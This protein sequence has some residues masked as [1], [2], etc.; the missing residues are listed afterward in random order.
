MPLQLNRLQLERE[1]AKHAW[2]TEVLSS[3]SPAAAIRDSALWQEA[4]VDC[5]DEHLGWPSLRGGS[6]DWRTSA[7]G[8]RG[9]SGQITRLRVD[10]CLVQHLA[11]TKGHGEVFL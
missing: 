5:T 8:G 7:G 6:G 3:A 4:C 9:G 11:L 1:L 10:G 2:S